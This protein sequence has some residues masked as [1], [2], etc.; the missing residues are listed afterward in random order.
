MRKSWL[1]SFLMILCLLSGCDYSGDKTIHGEFYYNPYTQKL[2]VYDKDSE[3]ISLFDDTSNQFQFRIDG[4]DDLFIDG[5][6]ISN[7]SRI[8]QVDPLQVTELYKFEKNN[9]IF[10][11]GIVEDR[12]YY[13]HSFYNQ[14][15]TEEIT[16]RCISAFDM[17][18]FEIQNYTHT[19]GLI[20]YAS[21]NETDIFYTVY[22]ASK[23]TYTLMRVKTGDVTATPEIVYEN[24]A[25]GIVLLDDEKI[26]CSDGQYLTSESSSYEMKSENIIYQEL[27]IQFHISQD[28]LLCIEVTNMET[29]EIFDKKDIYGIRFNEGNLQICS[30]TGVITYEKGN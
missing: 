26:F 11:I 5:N 10:P 28:G 12:F 2:V 8:I 27:L 29:G 7:E 30:Q 13:I 6:S 1:A 20:S 18:T 23:K 24:I 22:D 17:C 15:G 9:G 3:E 16:K 14:N 21:M 19:T 25:D 4:S